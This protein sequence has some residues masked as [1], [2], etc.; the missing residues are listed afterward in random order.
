M[1][2]TSGWLRAKQKVVVRC[3]NLSA[4]PQEM[5]AGTIISI[6]PPIEEN[7]IEEKCAGS[8]LA[9]GSLPGTR[10]QMCRL[11]TSLVR[12]GKTSLQNGGTV[13]ETGHLLTAYYDI[14]SQREDDVRRGDVIKH[15]IH[16]LG[17]AKPIQQLPRA[18]R[19]QERPRSQA[20]SSRPGAE[21]HDRTCR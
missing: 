11:C 13:H 9:A 17:G 12:E 8:E 7:Q 1:A 19:S 4:E 14:F 21:R 3:M 6:Y 16:H 15:C 2:A 18:A 10:F 5:K 20:T